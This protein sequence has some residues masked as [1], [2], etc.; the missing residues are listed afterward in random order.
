MEEIYNSPAYR[1]SRVAYYIQCV[2]EYLVTLLVADA[3][4]A[5]L[6][7]HVGM[8]DAT[9]GI[10]SSITS[11]AFLAQ[12]FTILL[13][14]RVKNVKRTVILFDVCSML[15]FMMTYLLPFL[16][17]GREVRTVLLFASIGSGF[18]LKYLQLNLYYKWGNSFVSPKKRGVFTARN[19]V[20]S[21][22]VGLVFSFVIGYVVDASERTGRIEAAF[23]IIAIVIA[24]LTV[25]DLVMLLLIRPYSVED[26]IRQQ[27][28]LCDVLKNTLGNRS[29]RNVVIMITL[30]DVARYLTIGFL[31]TFK[32]QELLYSVGAIQ[33]INIAANLLRCLLQGPMG[34]WSDRTSFAHVYRM[35]LWIC[36]GAFLLLMFTTSR[37]R[38]MVIGYT[39]LYNVSMAGIASNANNMTY[40][41]V[42]IDY[43]V[44][45]QAIRSSIAG[46]A[47]FLASLIGSRILAA[48][49]EHGNSV[50]G[51]PV[52]GQQVLA[53]ISLAILLI[54]IVFAKRVVEKQ[55]VMVQ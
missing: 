49:Q 21:L 35:G 6:L 18:A 5:K 44:Q 48:V 24:A 8:A 4:L 2:T 31:G 17:I 25:L 16:P 55:T 54:A 15:C 50:F 23:L 41:Y 7:K 37:T 3:F 52:Y 34:R 30:Y 12:L 43:F 14:R 19:N 26:A 36:A 1:R 22:A 11:L 33:I 28:P 38:W 46:T 39:V 13:M 42:P 53:L 27:K 32:T 10:V 9:V 47:G 45:A 40:S 29:F 20:I 51:V